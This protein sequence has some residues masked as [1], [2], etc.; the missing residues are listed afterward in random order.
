M[1]DAEVIFALNQLFGNELSGKTVVKKLIPHK[2]L[3]NTLREKENFQYLKDNLQNNESNWTIDI[4]VQLLE[5]V[6]AANNNP[7]LIFTK[8]EYSDENVG[9]KILKSLGGIDITIQNLGGI[10]KNLISII[11]NDQSIENVLT[12]FPELS[13]NM[14]DEGWGTLFSIVFINFPD[15]GKQFF[16]SFFR[17]KQS[18]WV[19][20]LLAFLIQSTPEIAHS[21]VQF[22]EEQSE[23]INIDLFSEFVQ[24]L[25]LYCDDDLVKKVCSQFI[26]K[27]PFNR[28]ENLVLNEKNTRSIIKIIPDIRAYA[29]IAD[30]AERVKESKQSI[31]I[32]RLVIKNVEDSILSSL[33]HQPDRREYSNEKSQLAHIEKGDI[34][35]PMQYKEF[36]QKMQLASK[37]YIS[38]RQSALLLAS[39]LYKI[40]IESGADFLNIIW[41][42]EFGFLIEP[43][44]IGAFFHDFGM[45]NEAHSCFK[46]LLQFFPNKLEVLEALAMISSKHG[47]FI[48]ANDYFFRI[49]MLRELSREE[50]LIF[51]ESLENSGNW[52]EAYQVRKK[53]NFVR[54]TD[55]ESLVFCAINAAIYDDFAQIIERDNFNFS[56]SDMFKIFSAFRNL[57]RGDLLRAEQI[58][59]EIDHFKKNDDR[60]AL[61]LFDYYKLQ[62]SSEKGV[63]VLEKYYINQ[64]KSPKILVKLLSYFSETHQKEKILEY[65][66]DIPKIFKNASI[67]DIENVL[68][69]LI[70]QGDIDTADFLIKSFEI[71]EPISPRYKSCK[72]QLLIEQNEFY[73]AAEILMGL[74]DSDN[75]KNI[76]PQWI[77]DYCLSKLES[78]HS[79][80]PLTISEK[81]SPELIT[82][83]NFYQKSIKKDY[84]TYLLE[85]ELGN[86]DLIKCYLDLIN[87]YQQKYPEEAWRVYGKLGLL[88]FKKKKFDLS[89][90]NIKEAIQAPQSRSVLLP[91]LVKSFIALDLWD[92]A[93]SYFCESL[94]YQEIS[95]WDLI[96][97]QAGF[98]KKKSYLVLL[99]NKSLEMSDSINL[100]ILLAAGFIDDNQPDRGESEIGKI[101]SLNPGIDQ[102]IICA[103][104]LFNA[105]LKN[106]ARRVIEV[107]ISNTKILSDEQILSCAFIFDQL[108][109]T[110]SVIYLIDQIQSSKWVTILY[111]AFLKTRKGMYVEAMDDL[112]RILKLSDNMTESLKINEKLIAA[113]IPDIWRKILAD[114][115]YI[116][117]IASDICIKAKNLQKAYLFL[118]MG[119]EK[120]KLNNPQYIN[121]IMDICLMLG[122]QE[123]IKKWKYSLE[124]GGQN[125]PS[126]ISFIQLGEIALQNGEE[127]NAAGFISKGLELDAK[128]P[129]LLA[130]QARLLSRQKNNHEARLIYSSIKNKINHNI[131]DDNIFKNEGFEFIPSY[132]W[133]AKAA[134]D[135]KDYQTCLDICI[136]EIETFGYTEEKLILFLECFISSLVKNEFLEKYLVKNNKIQIGNQNILF[137]EEITRI[138]EKEFN[139]EKTLQN[140][141]LICG[142]LLSKKKDQYAKIANLEIIKKFPGLLLE[143][144][145]IEHG[146]NSSEE[147]LQTLES[148]SEIYLIYAGFC[149][150]T[151][152]EK[153]LSYIRKALSIDP[154]NPIGLAGLAL[155]QERNGDIER[156]YS[157]ILLALNGWQDEY[158]WQILAARLAKELGDLKRSYEHLDKANKIE[159][160]GFSNDLMLDYL[161]EKGNRKAI[162]IL[163][164][165]ALSSD[166]DAILACKLG[167][168]FWRNRLH[169]KAVFYL[170]R[171]RDLDPQYTQPLLLL[172][173]IALAFNNIPQAKKYLEFVLD[174][175]NQ[176]ESAMTQISEIILREKDIQQAIAYLDECILKQDENNQLIIKKVEMI[177]K[178]FGI[179]PALKIINSLHEKY[180]T[181]PLRML[182]AQYLFK[183][184]KEE[185]SEFEA[186]KV[187]SINGNNPSIL[188]LLGKIANNQ[189]N[190]DKAIDFYIKA[191]RFDPLETQ[192]YISLAEIYDSRREILKCLSVFENALKVNE[193]NIDIIKTYIKF[194][195]KYGYKNKAEVMINKAL[196]IFPNDTDL[197]QIKGSFDQSS[198]QKN[199]N[200][201]EIEQIHQKGLVEI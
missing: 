190:L 164:S 6:H 28:F 44:R 145:F 21:F 159:D 64:T 107:I 157:S 200:S 112:D 26:D 25:T 170:E 196:D 109:E 136:R 10:S 163:E 1:S 152:P 186:E 137:F 168:L 84:I 66:Q 23:K 161:I 151:Q 184:G 172:S 41:D 75:E 139:S 67:A 11:K 149:L 91:I 147:L 193:D 198:I 51:A 131:H 138:I 43:E 37:I 31:D 162:K 154:D 197:K 175:D 15:H 153:A 36:F 81:P 16:R 115:S 32:L 54:L 123:K 85:C 133:L 106:Q 189:G 90:I 56:S 57:N 39:E 35:I 86:S 142:S 80:F 140:L 19:F 118:D 30:K 65:S 132:L 166:S 158:E 191:I 34:D 4:I 141:K 182:K 74:I 27:N 69:L 46:R 77:V 122:D 110:D 45:I 144:H 96:E 42:N 89:I 167:E 165:K 192:L 18:K 88:Y 63:S 72:A 114:L 58:I 129:R 14:I 101:L 125:E 119:K 160:G 12:F 201:M 22:L 5:N 71:D 33:N 93:I 47:D 7:P 169:A 177:E 150:E 104:L 50:K 178:T 194:L 134:Y 17:E 9:N 55:I 126:L 124:D 135:I 121:R 83:F 61:L 2:I 24:L 108:G 3:W 130:L 195:Q 156:A 113:R 199:E 38:D 183:L 48:A 52:L 127:I 92:E 59:G 179:E 29:V 62:N 103:Q 87:D 53:I 102:Q 68:R 60:I 174:V 76:D 180:L 105:G 171:S 155:S 148:D 173:D 117:L 95:I 49:S 188:S 97:L 176:N 13:R 187:L 8:E 20:S 100:R 146:I 70:D 79:M 120:I 73:K 82:V 111:R 143:T 181:I 116:Y 78:S 40:F 99:E 185:D 98:E 128:N 94:D